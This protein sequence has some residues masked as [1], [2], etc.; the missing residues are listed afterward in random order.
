MLSTSASMSAG[1]VS[2]AATALT[3]TIDS[4]PND[5]ILFNPRLDTDDWE[6]LPLPNVST[7][8]GDSGQYRWSPFNNPFNSAYLPLT[9][10]LLTQIPLEIDGNPV[11]IM[12]VK[13]KTM[14]SMWEGGGDVQIGYTG[15]SDVVDF[16]AGPNISKQ[17]GEL[18]KKFGMQFPQIAARAFTRECKEETG[19]DPSFS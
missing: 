19:F 2:A 18:E 11:Y 3:H 8:N 7:D 1:A 14:P 10:Q 4:G 6:V 12:G 5:L 16:A 13:Y 17:P 15:T 9:T